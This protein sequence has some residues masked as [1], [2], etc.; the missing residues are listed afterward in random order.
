M[1]DKVAA[2]IAGAGLGLSPI[3]LGGGL[4]HVGG[5]TSQQIDVS[6][7]LGLQVIGA[8]GARDPNALVIPVFPSASTSSAQVSQLIQSA[9]NTAVAL[10]GL[11]V[12]ATP[13]G[14]RRINLQANRLFTE[15]SNA[16]S[17]SL[18]NA[19]ESIKTY[20]NIVKV[21]GHTVTNRG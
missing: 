8:P 9:I 18:N 20:D 10:R 5:N 12:T 6:D 16:P 19:D 4:V 11:R 13:D 15:F 1:A 7:A 3:N 14:T 21:I 2:A 17:L